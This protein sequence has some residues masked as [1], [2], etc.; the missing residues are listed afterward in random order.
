[1]PTPSSKWQYLP[2]EAINPN[3]LALDKT[4]V[5][6]IIDL[7]VNE[8]RRVVAA[9]QKEKEAIAHG[10]EII[11]QALRKGGRLALVGAGTSGRLGIVEAAEIPPTFGTSPTLVQAV[12]AGGQPAVFRAKEGVEDNYEE[13]ARSIARLRLGKKDVVIGVSASGV[14]P[15]VRGALT[16][17]RKAGAK[18]IFITCWPG[19]ELKTFVDLL[20]AP[21]VGP[22][23]IAGSTRLKAGTATKMVLNM[24]TTIS[25]VKV[26][27]TYGNLM[28]D[29]QTGSEKLKDRARRI[30][31]IV[32]D[33]DYGEA[34]KLLRRARWNVKVAIVMQKSSVSYSEAVKRLRRAEESIRDAI[35]EDIE[36]RLRQLLRLDAAPSSSTNSTRG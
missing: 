28:V 10:V 23:I 32:T 24:L 18:I 3:T 29:V 2:T 27:K 15:F 22:E 25:M 14:T 21:A 17:A 5:P 4:P 30:I 20:I 6:E 35:G 11:T 13:G 1:M 33:I 16:R 19:S 34:D 7:I 31:M 12:M 26:G 8:D 36:P 9:V